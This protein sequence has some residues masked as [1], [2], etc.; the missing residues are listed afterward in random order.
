MSSRVRDGEGIAFALGEVRANLLEIIDVEGVKELLE[1]FPEC[2]LL[3]GIAACRELVAALLGDSPLAI[4]AAAVLVAP[5]MRQPL[6]LEFRSGGH[7]F[8]A[9]NGDKAENWLKNI[10]SNAQAALGS[11]L[12]VESLRLRLA[13]RTCVNLDVVH[14]PDRGGQGSPGLVS[15]APKIEEMRQRH[16][17]STANILVCLEPG[18]PLE[19]CR[20][21]DPG[22]QR[23]VLIG[24][25][26]SA[27][28]GGG[29]DTLPAAQ[30]CGPAAAR[31]LEERF[32]GLCHERVQ[33]WMAGLEKLEM[34]LSRSYM[35][36]R[37]VEQRVG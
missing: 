11:R 16:I 23:T 17:G 33:Q 3:G 22:M 36:A 25:A 1:R 28:Q 2:V 19:L 35:E 12:K 24:A 13:G 20:R 10:A 31:N 8:N 26:A 15:V 14:L 7:D 29:G 9:W 4:S 18:T 32:A 27:F 6:A 30:L 5:G 34:R 37:D 21:F